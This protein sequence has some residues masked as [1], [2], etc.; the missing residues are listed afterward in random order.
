MIFYYFAFINGFISSSDFENVLYESLDELLDDEKSSKLF[1]ELIETNYNSKEE[2][3]HI[4][5][6]IATIYKEELEKISYSMLQN[7]DDPRL[8]AMLK[9]KN[10][11]NKE[12]VFDCNG[13]DSEQKLHQKIKNIFKFPFWYGMNWDA[14]YDLLDLSEVEQIKFLHFKSMEH[15]I[16]IESEKMIQ[17]IKLKNKNCRIIFC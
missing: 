10:H 9:K 1:L 2:V 3:I 13:I 15:Y 8:Q 4:K 11:L 7:V 14:F 12:I 5:N 16:P 6:I 17:L